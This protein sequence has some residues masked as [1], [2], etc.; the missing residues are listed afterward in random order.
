MIKGDELRWSFEGSSAFFT[1][2]INLYLIKKCTRF[3][4]L[5]PC[6]PCCMGYDQ[7]VHIPHIDAVRPGSVCRA[8]ELYTKYIP[9]KYGLLSLGWQLPKKPS[10]YGITSRYGYPPES[11]L[12]LFTVVDVEHSTMMHGDPGVYGVGMAGPPTG[13]GHVSHSLVVKVL[14]HPLLPRRCF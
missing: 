13:Q 10:L 4:I 3:G 5:I 6:S 11:R 1:T 2:T 9:E 7:G 8:R 14:R 12:G